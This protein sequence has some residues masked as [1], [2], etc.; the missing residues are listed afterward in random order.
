[1]VYGMPTD[2][3]AP[4]CT[5]PDYDIPKPKEFGGSDM[6]SST[7]LINIVLVK[8]GGC[9]FTKKVKV[10]FDKGAH[11]VIF[12]DKEESDITVD[13][14]HN[15]VVADD[16]FG[17]KIKIPSVLV[18]KI[19][20]KKLIQA[21]QREQVIVELAW[22]LPTNHVVQLDMW[23][24]SASIQSNLFLR[25]F[26]PY[27]RKLNQ[28]VNFKPHYAVFALDGSDP[29]IYNELCTD[30]TGK[31]CAEDP[32][33]TGP[34]T[35][36]EVLM[37]DVR[38]M[39]I[40]VVHKVQRAS[41]RDLMRGHP[42]VEYAQQFWD[43]VEQFSTECPL[44]AANPQDRFGYD[45]S[46]RLMG[47]VGVD[48][49]R[50]E[51]CVRVNTTRYLEEQARNPAW[52]PRAM[53]INGWR[54]SGVLDPDLVTRA[55]CSGFIKRPAECEELLKPRDPMQPYEAPA[56]AGVSYG[57]MFLWILIVMVGL[58]IAFQVY[59]TFLKRELQRTLREEVMLEVQQQMGEYQKLTGR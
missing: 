38:Q 13:T 17:D 11:A 52:S 19:V 41:M 59:K 48:V 6:D 50:V 10:A 9:S 47:K 51:D 34:I 5:D 54:Y 37:E 18:D 3:K 39:C 21:A 28:V 8:R 20:G 24:S 22:D 29:K 16:G 46:K 58:G 56:P 30:D 35:G 1:L 40:H 7:H 31:F 2:E 32:D 27:R 44:D 36:K 26:A 4:H 12:C 57:E 53:R 45:C 25:A 42:G 55:I 15:I 43:Y 23:M 14:I 49:A 33:A